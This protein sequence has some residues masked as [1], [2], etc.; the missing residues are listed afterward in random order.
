MQT[1]TLSLKKQY[2]VITWQGALVT[3]EQNIE[4]RR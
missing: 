4:A 3:E 2:F 1:L